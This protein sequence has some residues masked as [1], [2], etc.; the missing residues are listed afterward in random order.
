MMH[1]N[2]Q[3]HTSD[4]GRPIG[5]S[6]SHVRCYAIARASATFRKSI[7]SWCDTQDHLITSHKERTG[8]IGDHNKN[9]DSNQFCLHT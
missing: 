4:R 1:G 3:K 7:T 6:V 8:E 2:I 9:G 5:Q